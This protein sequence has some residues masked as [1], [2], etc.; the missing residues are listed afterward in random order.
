ML[1]EGVA[2]VTLR[3]VSLYPAQVPTSRDSPVHKRDADPLQRLRCGEVVRRDRTFVTIAP[4]TR[5]AALAK[6]VEAAHDQDAFPVV[7]GA[8]TLRGVI[9]AEALRVVA[10][11][12]ELHSVGVAA[13]LMGPPVS[14]DG[15]AV[16]RDAA[17]LM[18]TRDLRSLPVI[19]GGAIVGLLDE[20]DIARVMI[21]AAESST[22]ARS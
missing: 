16:L 3:R 6:L 12:P 14:I 8:G 15:D 13:D 19:A 7:D 18:L 20:H 11:N 2:V 22:H 21:D 17:K 9:A 4:E 10:S 1:A 5:I